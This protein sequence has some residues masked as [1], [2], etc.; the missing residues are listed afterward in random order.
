MCSYADPRDAI[1]FTTS[2]VGR[3]LNENKD[4]LLVQNNKVVQP[5]ATCRRRIRIFRTS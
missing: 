5:V 1:S 4:F 2:T 3:Q